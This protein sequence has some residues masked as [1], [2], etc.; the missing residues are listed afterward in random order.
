M[1]LAIDTSTSIASLALSNNGALIAEITWHAGQNHTVE[2]IPNVIQILE[3]C[4]VNIHDV[5]AI[6]VAKGPGSFNGL[7]G[8]IA[9]AKG[10]AFALGIPLVGIS[11]LE[12]TAFPYAEVRLP[13]CPIINAGRGEIATALFQ[14]HNGDWKRLATEHITT[15]DKLCSETVEQT[16]FCGEINA[17]QSTHLKQ[18]LE[19]K[20][21]IPKGSA[22]LRRAGYLAELGWC[23]IESGG[24]D[25]PSTLQPLYLRR[26]AITI[27]K[28]AIVHR[29]A[30]RDR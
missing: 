9:T 30:H 23:K 21:L 1:E 18:E 15:I 19:N 25:D 24:F 6:M 4:K 13:I 7:R 2:L 5:K 27:P 8:G 28:K 3:K 12:V 11:T 10:L 22:T 17:E 26:P 29:G 14:A 16:I 20:A